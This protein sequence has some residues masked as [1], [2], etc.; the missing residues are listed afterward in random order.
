MQLLPKKP[1]TR[2]CCTKKPGGEPGHLLE[3]QVLHLLSRVQGV[4]ATQRLFQAVKLGMTWDLGKI[5]VPW[6]FMAFHTHLWRPV[7]HV[8]TRRSRRCSWFEPQQREGKALKTLWV[9]PFVSLDHAAA[10]NQDDLVL[11]SNG[12]LAANGPNTAAHPAREP[13]LEAGGS[14]PNIQLQRILSIEQL[15]SERTERRCFF[16]CPEHRGTLDRGNP[17]FV[18]VLG[19]SSPTCWAPAFF[20]NRGGIGHQDSC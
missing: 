14:W 1:P 13:R 5:T 15:T 3:T 18:T 9:F 19:P 17:K 20:Q 11:S 7:F 16:V 4:P 8:C 6:C 2:S 10:V 12:P